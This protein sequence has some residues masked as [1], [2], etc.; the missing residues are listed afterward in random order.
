M[1]KNLPTSLKVFLAALITVLPFYVYAGLYIYFPE[2]FL[3]KNAC[4]YYNNPFDGPCTPVNSTHPQAIF[5]TWLLG[6]FALYFLLKKIQSRNIVIIITLGTCLAVVLTVF[7]FIL[8]ATF[9]KDAG[10][11]ISV[12]TAGIFPLSMYPL[13]ISISERI[14][15]ARKPNKDS[16]ASWLNGLCLI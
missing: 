10:F 2:Y 7:T 8:S 12:I 6:V 14:F 16:K 5:I 15:N 9:T 13:S 4:S 3:G 11:L 1:L